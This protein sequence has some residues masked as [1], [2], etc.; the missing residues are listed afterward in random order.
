[1]RIL[2]LHLS[3]LHFETEKCISEKNICE[4]TSALSPTSIGHVDKIFVFVT[5]DIGFSGQDDQYKYFGK[6]RSKLI[7]FLKQNVLADQLIHIYIVPGNHD[8][9]YTNLDRDRKRC[10]ELLKHPQIYDMSNELQ[11]MSSFLK[12]SAR[13]HSLTSVMPFF[14][15][16]IVEVDGFTIEIN[17][18]NSAVFSLQNENDQGV[19][20]LSNDVITQLAA[21]TGA[22]MAVTLMHHSH[23]WFSDLCK[24]QL[25]KALIEKNTMVFC[26]HEHFQATQAISYNGKDPVHFFCGGSLCNRDDWSTSEYFACVYDTTNYD[27][28][29]FRFCWD[30]NAQIYKRTLVQVGKLLPK[31]SHDLPA[32]KNHIFEQNILGDIHIHL[33][34]NIADY[35]VFP[36]VTKAVQHKGV[37]PKDIFS[38]D[39]FFGEID[40]CNRIEISGSDTF[41]KSALLKMI[42]SHY[43]TCKCV[44]FCKVENISSGNRRRI[45]KTLFEDLYGEDEADFQ[46]FERLDKKEKMIL[47]DDIHMIDPK[48]VTSFLSGIE[49][50]FGYIIYTTSNTIKLD[51]EERIKSAI[52]KDSYSCFKINPMYSSQRKELVERV[53]KIKNPNMPV[54][55]LE[56][57]VTRIT[58]ALDLQRRYVPLTPEIIIKFI[59]YFSTYQMESAQNDGSIFGK[60]FESSIINALSPYVRSPLTVDKVF[61]ILG[62]IALHAHTN[63]TYPISDREILS[64]I[65]DYCEEYGGT[66]D[67]VSLI[68]SVI[69]S[70]VIV[71]YGAD[72]LYKFCNN[73]YYAYFIACEICNTKNIEAVKECLEAACFG[74]YSNI[75][76][77]VTYI[78]NEDSIIDMILNAALASAQDWKEFSFSMDEISHLNYRQ[79]SMSLSSPSKEDIQRDRQADIE[80]DREEID[81]F[82]FDVINVYDYSAEDIMKLENQLIRAISLMV[83][84]ARCLPNFEHRLKKTQKEAII[85]A[86][87]TVPN[88]I[89]YVWATYVEQL[90]DEML[91]LITT[92]ETN[93]FVRHKPTHED[94]QQILQWYSISLLLELYHIVVNSAYREN[95]EEFLIDMAK[96]QV[97][98]AEETHMI[99]YLLVLCNSNRISEFI[100]KAEAMKDTCKLP[101]ANLAL[102]RVVH[103]LLLRGKL[104]HK[105]ISQIESKFFPKANRS[106]TIYRRKLEK[107]KNS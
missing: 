45:I 16:N 11:S 61:L 2:F 85:T 42:Y 64:V 72:G 8:I 34:D 107:R 76:M 19:H 52:A 78:T 23:Q 30:N 32:V 56:P 105:Q 82:H 50:D 74:I 91:Q 1:M 84:I 6:F 57:M 27:Y 87:Y 55:E 33:S 7:E 51:I 93:M 80:K 101:A 37:Q 5:G 53:L 103:H 81:N 12:C 17:L 94:A 46:K 21:P 71:R 104:E 13:N 73:N 28:S 44:L 60:V 36:G 35:Y 41:G 88:K 66:I 68:N 14:T 54:I 97:S 20:F 92:M 43:A 95:T 10:E 65:E 106:A 77:F 49:E 96:G 39:A 86:L 22:H 70:R 31:Y 24:S 67:G 38:M 83:L 79:Q 18:L 63:R 58:Q 99:E 75:L 100:T 59:E 62:K 3:D 26:G 15:R 9:D 98:L 25:E 47:I 102:G 89:F 69:D 40:K 29:H 90:R 48:H 4:I